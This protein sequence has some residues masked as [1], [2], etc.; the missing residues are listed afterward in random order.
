MLF[1]PR[2]KQKQEAREYAAKQKERPSSV[3][4]ACAYASQHEITVDVCGGPEV[5]IWGYKAA[6]PAST[7]E[8][9]ADQINDIIRTHI[10]TTGEYPET[11]KFPV[12]FRR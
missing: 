4:Y 11:I 9:L 3:Q 12:E 6:L 5:S 8:G 2:R 10:L 1:D 7:W